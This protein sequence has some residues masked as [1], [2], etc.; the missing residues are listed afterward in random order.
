MNFYNIEKSVLGSMIT[1]EYRVDMTLLGFGVPQRT[2]SY[3]LGKPKW[4]KYKTDPLMM[5]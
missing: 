3:I 4:K 1:N 2:H 5:S